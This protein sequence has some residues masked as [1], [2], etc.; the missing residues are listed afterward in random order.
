MAE[1]GEMISSPSLKLLFACARLA[2]H[3]LAIIKDI[4]QGCRP[5]P[6]VH[7]HEACLSQE[8]PRVVI[9]ILGAYRLRTSLCGS[10]V[11]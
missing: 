4:A 11:A 8:N 1:V 9:M 5:E 6:S 7:S 3:S 10:F 2:G